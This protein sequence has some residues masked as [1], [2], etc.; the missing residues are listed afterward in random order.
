MSL[1]NFNDIMSFN[2]VKF[3]RDAITALA[4]GLVLRKKLESLE[5]LRFPETLGSKRNMVSRNHWPQWALGSQ[6]TIGPK[7]SLHYFGIYYLA[8]MDF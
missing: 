8:I 7:R 4:D 2:F 3:F 5:T 6:D 1:G